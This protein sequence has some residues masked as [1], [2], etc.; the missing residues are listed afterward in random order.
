[1]KDKKTHLQERATAISFWTKDF[2]ICG[3]SIRKITI[4]T[5]TLSAIWCTCNIS[6]LSCGLVFPHACA[7]LSGKEESKLNVIIFS[8][9]GCLVRFEDWTVRTQS[10]YLPV[11]TKSKNGAIEYCK[12]KNMMYIMKL[13]IVPSHYSITAYQI[14]GTSHGNTSEESEE[15]SS[16]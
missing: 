13:C 4:N 14:H 2:Q 9:V 11:F 6:N 16:Q 1:M 8:G 10:F 5:S 15:W 12:T 7:L 3:C